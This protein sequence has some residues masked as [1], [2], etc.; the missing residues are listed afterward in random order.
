MHDI[1]SSDNYV[2]HTFCD[3]SSL[4]N[5]PL[6]SVISSIT[7]NRWQGLLWLIFS[8]IVSVSLLFK[9]TSHILYMII[10]FIFY[11]HMV[12][13]TMKWWSRQVA[14]PGISK[15]GAEN[16]KGFLFCFSIFQGGGP[17]QQIAEKMIFPTTKVAK[18]RWNSLKFALMTFF[19]AFN[20]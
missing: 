12:Q 13:F 10:V 5:L 14:C 1:V 8:T 15:G 11:M 6:W 7:N 9:Q 19:F 17:A 16:L 20:F 2:F 4:R 18:Y 3:L